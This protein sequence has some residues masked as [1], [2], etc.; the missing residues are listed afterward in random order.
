[1]I[2]MTD[3]VMEVSLVRNHRTQRGDR[4]E[5]DQIYAGKTKGISQLSSVFI[6]LF[7]PSVCPTSSSVMCK[8]FKKR[9]IQ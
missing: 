9:Q 2:D 8:L 5:E 4:F 7:F 6:P 3:T 1:M